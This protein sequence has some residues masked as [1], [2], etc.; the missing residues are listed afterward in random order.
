M[1]QTDRKGT[2]NNQQIPIRCLQIN[3]QDS[4]AATDNLMHI[5]HQDHADIIFI[6]EPYL[7]QNKTA[8]IIRTYRT[9]TS[10]EDKS[11]AAIILTNDNIDAVLIK[12]LCDR[13]NVILE[14]RYKNTRILAA[15][16]YLD[17]NE[18][19]D[20]KTAKIDEIL[21]YS[22][23][24]GIL[25]AM[26]SN[27]RSTIW[28]DNQTN[29]RGKMLEERL[30]SRDSHIMNEESEL[31]TFQSRRDSSN[32]DLTIVNNRLLKNLSDWE[33]SEDNSCSD[34]NIIKFKIGHETNHEIQHNHNGPRY[35]INKQN[36]DRFDKNLKEF[37]ATKF[38]MENSEDLA[39][40]DSDLS[41]RFK[42]MSDIESAMKKLQE[43]VTM[44]CNRSFKPQDTTKKTTKQKPV[45]WWTKELTIKRERLNALRRCYQRTKNN[46]EL[47]EYRKNIYYEKKNIKQQ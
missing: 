14:L 31:T 39:S 3:L 10:N 24:S 26:D 1:A 27:S 18:E 28:H 43:A 41:K 32:I 7:Y 6:Q 8:G 9:Y 29:S 19:I 34:H 37:V 25:I 5:I 12:Q 15:S 36:Y 22:K 40:L 46:E 17:L 4:R 20:N 45:P 38:Q 11:R 13:D 33:I 35:I 2:N 42:E 21:Q 16:M 44:S 23:D 30:I 47:R